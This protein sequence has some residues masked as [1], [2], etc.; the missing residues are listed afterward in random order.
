MSS[1]LTLAEVLR[2]HGAE[3]RYEYGRQ[4]PGYQKQALWLFEHC[5]TASLG[6]HIHGCSTCGHQEYHHNSCRHR[7][8]PQCEGAKEAQWLVK[9]EEEL[10]PVHYFHVVFTVPAVLNE[11]FLG[12]QRECYAA[13]FEAAAKT[14]KTVGQNRIG[15]K[16]GFFAILHSWGQQLNFHP[17]LHCVVPGGGLASDGNWVST[18][19]KKRYLAPTKVLAEVFRGILLKRLAHHY[20]IGKLEFEGD[21]QQLLSTAAARKWVVSAKPPFGSPLAVLKY[22]SR[23]TRKVAISN[24]RLLE[25][26]DGKVTFKFR[27]YA[28]EAKEKTISLRAVEFL[29]RFAMHIPPPGFMRIRY[30]GFMAGAQRVSKLKAIA[31]HIRELLPEIPHPEKANSSIK[32]KL[33]SACGAATIRLFMVFH[34]PSP[35]AFNSS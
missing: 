12:N 3:L 22:L 9:R 5:R 29:R 1:K 34:V 19:K 33:C 15:A 30:Y 24:S 8:C 6:G 10:L 7:G 31:A 4:L 32:A 2:H 18:S 25:L 21:F 11:L 27:D 14:L 20:R 35:F 13:L 16:L 17:H 23:Y 28:N 26:K